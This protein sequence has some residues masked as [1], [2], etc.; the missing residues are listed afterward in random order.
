MS[1]VKDCHY[2]SNQSDTIGESRA[3]TP[4]K[5]R[6]DTPVPIVG[7]VQVTVKLNDLGNNANTSCTSKIFT[8]RITS[9]YYNRQ[10]ISRSHQPNQ[11]MH[12]TG[13][14]PQLNAIKTAARNL[15][16]TNY[17]YIIFT[18]DQSMYHSLVLSRK[19]MTTPAIILPSNKTKD[20]GVSGFH[21]G[22][23][24]GYERIKWTPHLDTSLLLTT[25]KFKLFKYTISDCII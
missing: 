19:F 13:I 12:T 10:Q 2:V 24:I 23:L 9:I 20:F 4:P 16:C 14:T 18:S 5:K 21:V 25:G 7:F 6:R 3:V 8:R 22:S 11:V 15:S 1:V 17:K